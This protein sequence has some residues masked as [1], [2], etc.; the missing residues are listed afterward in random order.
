HSM[1]IAGALGGNHL[2][3]GGEPLV[4]LAPEHATIIGRDYTRQQ[5]QEVL[6]AQARLP[7]SALP[8]EKRAHLEQVFGVS[9]KD[10][11]ALCVAER[12]SDIML[13]VLGGVGAKSTYVPTWGGTT[14]A[15][16]R[17]IDMS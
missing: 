5:T 10:Q 17:V 3:G 9:G 4:L 6:F 13:V 16:T 14:R 12:A 11:K 2:L 1:P 8:T 7:L 15:V